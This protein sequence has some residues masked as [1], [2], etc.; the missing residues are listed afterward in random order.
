MT[1][2]DDNVILGNNV[3][4][5]S[6]CV[7]GHRSTPS[8][9]RPLIIGDNSLIRS[10]SVFYA[11]ST[12]GPGLVTGH[13]VTVREHIDAGP[14]LQIGTLSDL[15]GHLRIG[16]HVRTHSNVHL[17]QRSVIGNYV[18]IFPYTVLTNDPHPPSDG[19]LEGV[20][21]E[22]YA[23]LATMSCIMPGVTVGSR[24][25]VAAHSL[26]NRDVP[27]DT[28]VAGVPAKAVGPTSR[29]QLRD[30]SGPAYPWMR[31]FHRGY[32]PEVVA[33]WASKFQ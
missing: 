33:E 10:H 26:V 13:H 29:V 31:H 14:G 11:G 5:E 28:V 18:W 19:Y 32:P 3:T 23:V 7:I 1:I 27:P 4:V 9:D 20:T 24:S 15:Q 17:G 22:D 25:L 12:F 21:V 30:G 16:A 6:H 2:V 8:D